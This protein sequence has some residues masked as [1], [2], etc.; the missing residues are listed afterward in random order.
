VDTQLHGA[1]FDQA[2]LRGAAL[3]G[4]CLWRADARGASWKD[5]RVELPKADEIHKCDWTEPAFKAFKQLISKEVPEDAYKRT[6]REM[7]ERH[8]DPTKTLEGEDEMAEIWATRESAT[9]PPEVY[10]RSLAGI[11]RETGCAAEGAPYV[12]HG[13]VAQLNMPDN[14]LFREHSDAAKALAAAF[15]DE[16]HCA[17]AHGLSEADKATLEKLAAPATP[18]VPKP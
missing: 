3:V 4:V 15:L 8:L 10:E 7:V 9:P 14:S 18:Q 2:E 12:L 11:W 16:A 1:S 13:L 5:T 6:A 17:G